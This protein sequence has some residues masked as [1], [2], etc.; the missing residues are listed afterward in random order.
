[1]KK[2]R[3]RLGRTQHELNELNKSEMCALEGKAKTSINSLQQQITCLQRQSA[4]DGACVLACV[5]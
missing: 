3:T 4:G 5:C 1:M 2:L